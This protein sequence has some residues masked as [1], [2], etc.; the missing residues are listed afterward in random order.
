MD[1]T[2]HKLLVMFEG[3]YKSNILSSLALEFFFLRMF[4]PACVEDKRGKWIVSR[5]GAFEHMT[6]IHFQKEVSLKP[7]GIPQ[8]DSAEANSDA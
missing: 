3:V 2:V 1:S 8:V 4:N 7:R 6:C 5:G